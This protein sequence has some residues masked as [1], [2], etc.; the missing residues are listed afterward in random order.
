MKIDDL[1]KMDWGQDKNLLA[2]ER[3]LAGLS[4]LESRASIRLAEL[5]EII[6]AAEDSLVQAR[7][8]RMLN[9]TSDEQEAVLHERLS[10]SRREIADL[11]ADIEAT[12]LAKK[13]LEP[14]LAAAASEARL[15]MAQMLLA[16][17]KETTE[18]LQALLR[19]AVELNQLLHA[20]HTYT[21]KHNLGGEIVGNEV[22]KPL[23]M[24]AAWNH[25]SQISGQPSG[26][27]AYWDSYVSAIFANN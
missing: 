20:I 8:A 13:R 16:P 14:S 27:Y 18:S 9:E 11:Q 12:K 10:A 19:K 6:R 15:R 1:K 23:T 7:V 21:V 22:L 2:L 17:Y 5:Q 25:L 4:D 24:L 3:K 26:D